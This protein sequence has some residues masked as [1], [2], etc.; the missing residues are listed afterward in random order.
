MSRSRKG[1]TAG[2]PA[3]PGTLDEAFAWC[4]ANEVLVKFQRDGT[5]RVHLYN[6]P[7]VE[8][9]T[10]LEAVATLADE[11]AAAEAAGRSS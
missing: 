7:P 1:S 3:R 2:T 11:T 8:R 10:V 6:R 4:H 5:V 9:A